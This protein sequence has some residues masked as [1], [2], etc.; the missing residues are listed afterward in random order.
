[1]HISMMKHLP[2][3]NYTIYIG[4]DKTEYSLCD[5]FELHNSKIKASIGNTFKATT[6]KRYEIIYN[7]IKPFMESQLKIKDILLK[8]LNL[9]LINQFQLYLSSVKKHNPNTYGHI[10]KRLRKVI[11]FAIDYN[12][13]DKDP[14]KGYQ[15]V[16]HKKE[17]VFLTQQELELL[18]GY[19]FSQTRLQ[20]VKNCF[21]FCCYTGLPYNE[22]SELRKD[23]FQWDGERY[24]II[25]KRMKTSKN[26]QIP[27]LK[28][29]KNILDKYDFE[30]NTD[31]VLPIIRYQNFNSYLKELADV[32]GISKKLTHH[33]AR[34][35]FASTV[36]LNNDVPMHVVSELLGHSSIKVTE[37]YYGRVIKD[38]LKKEIN[39]IDLKQCWQ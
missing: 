16:K 22:F 5:A 19:N 36:L 25:I 31:K 28:K 14:F 21:L 1:M 33:I 24:W 10:C 23:H 35:T 32:I 38:K 8:D 37:E 9:T 7:H 15:N 13:T 6:L 12:L 17:V 3:K 30:S 34:K 2:F 18:E 27:L 39:R 11:N 26:L 4:K 29:A 20:Q